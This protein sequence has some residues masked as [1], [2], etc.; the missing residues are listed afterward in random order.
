[1]IF[2]FAAPL[3]AR[4]PLESDVK[5]P[6]EE[7]EME[8]P[9]RKEDP[10]VISPNF[11]RE[12]LRRELGR[13]DYH[14]YSSHITKDSSVCWTGSSTF[15][16]SYRNTRVS[17]HMTSLDMPRQI[18]QFGPYNHSLSIP[19][20]SSYKPSLPS[21]YPFC[22]SGPVN[23]QK[24]L[25]DNQRYGGSEL[26]VLKN[27]SASFSGHSEN[28]PRSNVLNDIQQSV[29]SKRKVLFDWEPSAPFIP[30]F[31]ITQRLLSPGSL[32]DPIRDSIEQ[33]SSGDGLPKSCYSG[34]GTSKL[35]A[36]H[37]DAN[38]V[39]KGLGSELNFRKHPNSDHS[40]HVCDS[41]K[42]SPAKDSC[43][44]VL[45]VDKWLNTDHARNVE[46]GDGKQRDHDPELQSNGSGYKIEVIA[47]SSGQNTKADFDAYVQR[48]CQNDS[49]S[50][51]YFHAA[52][53]E[54]LKELLKPTWHEGVISKDAHKMIVKRAVDKVIG[55]LQPDQIP[56]TSES[57]RHYLNVS[58]T[59]LAKLIE[60]F[61]CVE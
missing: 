31:Y 10:L 59:K 47:E 23:S 4:T 29:G 2:L 26:A 13:D 44:T 27:G 54:F 19:N 51:K 50:L 6:G 21:R 40:F 28:I 48:D 15:S 35:A 41:I 3:S 5:V 22:S 37:F 36:Q 38:L 52:L 53:V 33:T 58:K 12:S 1:M 42:T 39:S 57:I 32:Y 7:S 8:L 49:R 17:S 45:M 20:T 56:S 46:D 25:D 34:V 43:K 30:S 18:S 9:L 14:H 55:S 11:G 16:E 24:L 60:V 61:F